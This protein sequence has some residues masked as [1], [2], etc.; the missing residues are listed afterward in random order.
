MDLPPEKLFALNIIAVVAI[1]AFL[2]V[3]AWIFLRKRDGQ[4]VLPVA[5]RRPVPWRGIDIV[6]FIFVYLF[7]CVLI[8]GA[9]KLLSEYQK[10][11]TLK[12]KA[13]EI[14]T[15]VADDPLKPMVVHIES[16][17]EAGT[18][19]K[20]RPPLKERVHEIVLALRS[21]DPWMIGLCFF[22]AVIFAPISEEIVFRM[23]IQGYLEKV[24][25]HLRV[26]LKSNRIMNPY[27]GQI[28]SQSSWFTMLPWGVAPILITSFVFAMMHFR[29]AKEA[30]PVEDVRWIMLTAVLAGTISIVALLLWLRLV[31]KA[32]LSDFGIVPHE[33]PRDIFRGLV[34]FSAIVVPVYALQIG[35]TWLVPE[36]FAPDPIPIFFLSVAFGTVWC[37]T[38]RL[39][40]SVVMHMS[41]NAMSMALAMYMLG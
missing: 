32:R 12:G 16:S 25:G 35:A 8:G 39:V 40:P 29:S 9:G 23:F 11:T 4:P 31:R 34:A 28:E 19:K 3:W 10:T 36:N 30:P 2:G 14:S 13:V 1:G 27:T 17:K 5:W 24:D 20:V 37:R 22:L 21:G 7:L 41:L 18:S 33:I 15:A 6:L 38:H 26:Q